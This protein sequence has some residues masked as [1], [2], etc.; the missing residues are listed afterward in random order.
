M[1]ITLAAK[2]PRNAHETKYCSV[3]ACIPLSLAT[4]TV[5]IL[6]GMLIHI[7]W[8]AYDSVRNLVHTSL[9]TFVKIWYALFCFILKHIEHIWGFPKMGVSQVTLF[10]LNTKVVIHFPWMI[11]GTPMTLRTSISTPVADHH[12]EHLTC[13][14][15]VS[16]TWLSWHAAGAA[17]GSASALLGLRLTRWVH[18]N[19]GKMGKWYPSGTIGIWTWKI[20]NRI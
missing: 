4:L 1:F 18:Q 17:G 20:Y 10:G 6:L 15:D 7:H 14:H 5:F 19:M 11:W 9:I 8:N 2:S 13:R 3:V 16:L 12:S